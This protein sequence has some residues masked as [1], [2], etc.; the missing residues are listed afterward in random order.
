M[1]GIRTLGPVEVTVNGSPAPAELLW[2][3]NL[4]LVIYL[5]RSP[6]RARARDHLIGLLWGDKSDEKARRSLNEALSELRRF[7]GDDVLI[8]DIAQ[9]R[10]KP[11]AVELDTDALEAL[12]AAGD[13][14]GAAALAHGEF[15]EGFSVPGAQDFDTWLAAERDHWS[16]RAVD[17]LV[18]RSEQLLAAADIAAALDT[19]RRA[20]GLDLRSETALRAM[21]R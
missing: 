8:S 20:R 9:V 17:I 19:A 10:L 3:K 12:A 2:K 7:G 6:K 18:R 13:Y 5:A 4:A 1:I 16:R 14:G 21:M 11:G 15:L